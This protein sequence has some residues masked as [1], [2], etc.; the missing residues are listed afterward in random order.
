MTN[1]PTSTMPSTIDALDTTRLITI[2][3]AR[4]RLRISRWS[5]YQL[6]NQR[7]LKTITIG[8]RRLI[9]P[10]DFEAFLQSRRT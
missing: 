8:S 7:Q 9:T 3:E 10:Q 1:T 4:D 2:D 6:I 5:I